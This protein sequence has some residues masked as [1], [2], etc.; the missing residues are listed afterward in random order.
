PETPPDAQLQLDV[1]LSAGEFD[2]Q[3]SLE[4][5]QLW[6]SYMDNLRATAAN[7]VLTTI[8][9]G[10]QEKLYKVGDWATSWDIYGYLVS[11]GYADWQANQDTGLGAV[12]GTVELWLNGKRG[13]ENTFTGYNQ[14]VEATNVHAMRVAVAT[15]MGLAGRAQHA[16]LHLPGSVAYIANRFSLDPKGGTGSIAPVG[17]AATR[18]PGHPD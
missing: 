8:G 17:A 13:Q 10:T 9:Q 4:Q 7:D 14:L 6:Q 2:L 3:R 5:T 16:S 12:T 15:A 18:P 11:G 1:L